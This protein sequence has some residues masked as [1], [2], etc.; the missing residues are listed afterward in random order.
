MLFPSFPSSDH[1]SHAAIGRHYSVIYPAD[2]RTK[3][4]AGP[5]GTSSFPLLTPSR[6]LVGANGWEAE[7]GTNTISTHAPR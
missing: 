6:S 5:R 7:D 2:E 4:R 1:P 3:R